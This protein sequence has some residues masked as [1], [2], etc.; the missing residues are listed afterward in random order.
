VFKLKHNRIQSPPSISG[1][2]FILLILSNIS[3][4][5]IKKSTNQQREQN[6]IVMIDKVRA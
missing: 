5:A 3:S 2:V 4:K 6:S 1:L